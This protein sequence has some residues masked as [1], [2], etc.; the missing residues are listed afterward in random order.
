[1]WQQRDSLARTK[2][3]I[4]LTLMEQHL[5]AD[6]SLW[7]PSGGSYAN[8]RTDPA[9]ERPEG[10]YQYVPEEFPPLRRGIGVFSEWHE[11]SLGESRSMRK[12]GPDL[13]Q[14]IRNK[15]KLKPKVI[16][17]RLSKKSPADDLLRVVRDNGNDPLLDDALLV[18]GGDSALLVTH[19]V[20]GSPRTP[21]SCYVGRDS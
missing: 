6:G 11:S 7:I 1:M 18:S 12:T 3:P 17:V 21:V 15:E 9:A 10:F 13:L 14:R 20:A 2:H 8:L 19:G 4:H 5:N 16:R